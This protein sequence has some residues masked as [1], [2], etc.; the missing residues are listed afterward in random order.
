MILTLEEEVFWVF[1]CDYCGM[2]ML[3]L[4]EISGSHYNF[5]LTM[6]YADEGVHGN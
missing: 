4:C 1:E 2:D 5:C 3:V 6:L